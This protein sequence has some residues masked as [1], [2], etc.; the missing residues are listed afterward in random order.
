M[1]IQMLCAKQPY[2]GDICTNFRWIIYT[3]INSTI[4]T[5]FITIVYENSRC[6][7]IKIC[8]LSG[9]KFMMSSQLGKLD[10]MGQKSGHKGRKAENSR[11]THG[12]PRRKE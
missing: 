11:L 4:Y 5:Q 8:L 3:F 10:D 12:R 2:H 7:E 9:R 6:V 1:P